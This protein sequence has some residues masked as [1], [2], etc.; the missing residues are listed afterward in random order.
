MPPD[1]HLRTNIA[2]DGSSWLKPPRPLRSAER[3]ML[4]AILAVAVPALVFLTIVLVG[5]LQTPLNPHTAPGLFPT[6][7]FVVPVPLVIAVVVFR[8]RMARAPGTVMEGS[9]A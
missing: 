8:L 5:L 1:A 6:A 9:H 7:S 2:A 3:A 4:R